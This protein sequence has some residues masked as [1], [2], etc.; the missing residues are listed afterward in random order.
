MNI[1]SAPDAISELTCD[2]HGIAEEHEGDR[3][4]EY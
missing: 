4:V 2:L 3:Q 1:A